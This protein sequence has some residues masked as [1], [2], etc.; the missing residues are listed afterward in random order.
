VKA[1]GK[2]A[3]L[4]NDIV[5]AL[6]ARLEHHDRWE[7]V[8]ALK[9]SD[10]PDNVVETP[11]TARTSK[12]FGSKS[13]VGARPRLIG[14]SLSSYSSYTTS[15]LEQTNA[16]LGCSYF[17]SPFQGS[18]DGLRYKLMLAVSTLNVASAHKKSQR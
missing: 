3:A 14:I 13:T 9:R 5:Q 6:T 4:P 2:Q 18:G 12:Q 1:L 11:D 16:A 17:P 8:E 7:D 10:V 15:S